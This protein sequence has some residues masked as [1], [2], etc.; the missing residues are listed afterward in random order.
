MKKTING[1]IYFL[2]L[3]LIATGFLGTI[4]IFSPRVAVAQKI[5]EVTGEIVSLDPVSS[6]FTV[7]EISDEERGLAENL[8]FSMTQTTTVKKGEAN[9]TLSDIQMGNKVSVSYTT[10]ID[11][12]NIAQSILVK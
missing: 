7:R 11:D 4:E 1:A 6:T 9:L 8:N 5:K 2:F 12:K 10:T 3:V